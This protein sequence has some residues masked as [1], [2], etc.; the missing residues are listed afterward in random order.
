MFQTV[1]WPGSVT[2]QP[3]NFGAQA[4]SWRRFPTSRNTAALREE[5]DALRSVIKI[6][7]EQKSKT[8]NEQIAVLTKMDDDGVLEAY[9]LLALADDGIAEDYFRYLKSNRDQLRKYVMNYVVE[10]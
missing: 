8:T 7:K 10:K 6:A 4:N 9:I 1:R 3:A 5:A 2:L